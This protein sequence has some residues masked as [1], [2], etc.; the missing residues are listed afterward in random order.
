[1]Y[2]HTHTDTRKGLVLACSGQVTRRTVTLG[3]GGSFSAE[4]GA[5]WNPWETKGN[6]VMTLTWGEQRSHCPGAH[7]PGLGQ[8]LSDRFWG[9]KK[10]PQLPVLQ[11]DWAGNPAAP[12]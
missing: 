3:V 7:Q 10:G 4:H 9:D 2:A 11:D 12:G 8:R 5:C 1:M 6:Q